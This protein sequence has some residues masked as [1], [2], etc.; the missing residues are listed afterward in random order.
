MSLSSRLDIISRLIVSRKLLLHVGLFFVLTG[1]IISLVSMFLYQEAPH[2]LEEILF[3][4]YFLI[5]FGQI[6]IFGAL[7]LT[8]FI[9]KHQ[10]MVLFIIG[11]SF[12]L[13]MLPLMPR[14]ISD[15]RI[16][17]FKMLGISI[18]G[19]LALFQGKLVMNRITYWKNRSH[20]KFRVKIS[21]FADLMFLIALLFIIIA[22]FFDLITKKTVLLIFLVLLTTYHFGYLI[23][24][25][26]D[27][28]PVFIDP[29]V[30]EQAILSGD[31]SFA[32]Y[33]FG[34]QG[35]QLSSCWFPQED[36]LSSRNNIFDFLTEL[37]VKLMTQSGYGTEY[38]P[39]LVYL[40][41]QAPIQRRVLFVSFWGKVRDNTLIDSRFGNAPYSGF[42]LLVVPDLAF[43]VEGRMHHWKQFVRLLFDQ[44]FVDELPPNL[45]N[46]LLLTF[47]TSIFIS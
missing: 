12:L 42:C 7:F 22:I 15:V 6:F 24:V 4:G 19:V 8:R 32:L 20:H 26:L 27:P 46:S 2:A 5:F 28:R 37:G 39:G 33:F 10:E 43:L 23:Q 21:F 29:L 18:I 9:I 41:I 11:I 45:V 44:H 36:N 47:I 30:I 38:E 35:P 31:V 1:D 40:E 3:I 14:F 13:L 34:K 17:V 25:S 16:P